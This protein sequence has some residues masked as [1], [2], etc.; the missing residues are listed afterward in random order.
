MSQAIIGMEIVWGL[1]DELQAR[2]VSFLKVPATAAR[3]AQASKACKHLVL[4]RLIAAKAAH[5][6]RRLA[7]LAAAAA[8]THSP[9]PRRIVFNRAGKDFIDTY[10]DVFIG[11]SPLECKILVQQILQGGRSPQRPRLSENWTAQTVVSRLKNARAA[12]N[13][14]I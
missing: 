12:R 7:V 3:F 4:P 10:L 11:A 2:C 5:N 13:G 6:W 1:P 8:A 9:A 14:A